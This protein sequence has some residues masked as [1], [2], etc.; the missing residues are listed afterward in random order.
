MG[1]LFD[2]F[3]RELQRRRAEAE[4]QGRGDA[5]DPGR[6]T[7]PNDGD[8][9]DSAEDGEREVDERPEAPGEADS[10][11]DEAPAGDRDREP[12]PLDVR[13]RRAMGGLSGRWRGGPG[14]TAG[15]GAGGAGRGAGGSGGLGAAGGGNRDG[16]RDGISRR[17]AGGPAD[18]APTL[19]SILRRAG[20]AVAILAALVVVA[21]LG[22]GLDLWTDALW[23]RSV[24]YDTVFWTRLGVQLAL[25]AGVLV[26]ALL[27]L[28]ANLWLAGRLV[29]PPD[30]DRPG[31][32]R[33]WAERL[34]EAMQRAEGGVDGP[35]GPY[36]PRGPIGRPP[37]PGPRPGP[38][39]PTVV[40][41]GELPD[42]TPIARWVLGGFALLVALG[43][44]GGASGA[45]EEIV[46]WL[47]RVPFG[48]GGAAVRDPIFGRDVSFFLFELP[49]FRVVQS[50][51]NAL[52]LASLAIAFARYV[53]AGARGGSVFVTPVRVH[54]GVLGGLY[55]ASV[56][57]G[58]QLDK[59]ELAFGVN[60]AAPGVGYTDQNARFIAYDALTVVSALAAALLV[61]GAFTRWIRP[62]YLAVGV[63][64]LAGIVLGRLYP[65]AIQRF[66]VQP[67]APTR[68][69]PYIGNNIAMTRLAFGIDAWD[70]DQMFRGEA[71]LT[72]AA[73]D[74]ESPTFRNARLWDY[75]P[76]QATLD[77][78]QTVRQYYDF[79]DV[80]TDRYVV[81]DEVRQVMLSGRELDL[82][83]NPEATGWVNE[84][85]IYTHGIGL[86]MVPVN[87]VTQEGQPRLWIR[88]LPPASSSGAPEVR[89]PRIYFGE[90]ASEYVIVGAR[91]DEFDYPRG[92]GGAEAGV[93]NRWQGTTG[94]RLDTML[95]RVLFALRFRDLDLLISD[96]I[97]TESQLLFR[98]SLRDRVTRIA[99]FLRYDKDPYLVVDGRGRL[100]Y[101]QDAYTWSARFPHATRFD[102]SSLG[103]TT[104][105]DGPSFN[106]LRNSVKIV[107]DA[108]DGTLT[109]YAAQPD[110]PI[111]RAWSGVFPGLFRSF[112]ELPADLVPHVRYPEELFN[113][114][115]R[116]F[117][118]YHLRPDQT[119]TFYSQEDL[120]QVPTG[121]TTDQSLP[122]EAYYVIMR[123]PGEAESEFLLLQPMI[124]R[125]RP[126]MIA[127]VAAR[128]DPGVYGQVRVY[129]FPVETNVFGPAQIE[130]RIDQDP[131]I[132][133]QITLWSQAGSS[134]IRG[135]LLVVPVGE[136]LLYLQPVY[137]QSTSAAFPE[138]ER[139]IVASPTTVVWGETLGEA[140]ELLL[141]E[142][143][144]GPGPTPSPGPTP[145]PEPG[146]TP[147]PAPTTSPDAGLPD[148]VP[149]LIEYANQHFDLAQRAL[150]EGDFA[151]Y[152]EEMDRVEAALE[153]LAE[154][155]P[156]LA[157]TPAP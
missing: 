18:G 64:F 157:P 98:R 141:E 79:I 11:G 82:S 37:S 139:I 46:L 107:M 12:V 1:D 57:V 66:V 72:E 124:P 109:F 20:L 86:A 16:G 51:A 39:D 97:T 110:E 76:L 88:D 108:Y 26:V 100:V 148:D 69:A 113:V 99:P 49:T 136:S 22:V 152:G 40:F 156:G 94:I 111:L 47:N 23:Y 10:A 73:I 17:G 29:P 25:F 138:F 137:L 7:R 28:L 67:N 9:G 30:P 85:L 118:R 34:G 3:M 112:D 15:R 65:E 71:P 103:P 13:R 58:Y 130:A 83:K 116:V 70:D 150:R 155:S 104:G 146:A 142:Q 74:N 77:Q 60:G 61:G 120:W 122:N 59:F 135:N 53:V 126:N 56:A 68:E 125:N 153:R 115:T 62:L 92:S 41:D 45:W 55:L 27:V 90:R 117:G 129:R 147:T 154:L 93:A 42:L 14:R 127:W 151:T 133:A 80:D 132:S 33:S 149:G 21:L 4:G 44:A 101:V 140:L 119:L 121:E 63:W 8:R 89:E 123:M 91:Q 50:L 78:L 31:T 75:R 128:N 2:E 52:I 131:I 24:G 43:I 6:P 95:M 54:L 87:E 143:G 5:G 144:N 36:G 105:I 134:V 84:R 145:T 35:Y 102:P 114:Q 19:G 38:R 48:V 96:Q 81:G 32:F 106:Y